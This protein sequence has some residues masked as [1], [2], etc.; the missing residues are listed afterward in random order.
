MAKEWDPVYGI[1]N[2]GAEL[3]NPKTVQQQQQAIPTDLVPAE[4]ALQQLMQ[5]PIAELKPV[6]TVLP[7]FPG[8]YA[9]N[10]KEMQQYS[11]NVAS[12]ETFKNEKPFEYAIK[13]GKLLDLQAL[14]NINPN[15]SQNPTYSS[16]I[17]QGEKLIPF[18][19]KKNIPLRNEII[20]I[21]IENK[22][23]PRAFLSQVLHETR[24]F[25]DFLNNNPGGV[26]PSAKI[27]AFIKS[28]PVEIRRQVAEKLTQVKRTREPLKGTIQQLKH[29]FYHPSAQFVM[30]KKDIEIISLEPDTIN[31]LNSTLKQAQLTN[32]PESWAI[33]ESKLKV[34][35]ELNPEKSV[36]IK[37]K[38]GEL[39]DVT[40]NSYFQVTQPFMSYQQPKHGFLDMLRAQK[41]GRDTSTVMWDPTNP[42][43]IIRLLDGKEIGRYK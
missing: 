34:L 16:S 42:A 22:I 20:N 25:K 10:T 33:L 8:P 32:D 35:R 1:M 36:K 31:E 21:A 23:D 15:Y 7:Q 43:E 27:E 19:E 29:Y 18:I 12:F 17:L 3:L 41:G 6:M 30:P 4:Q 5:Q 37:N 26:K 40:K 28:Q 24:N 9:P 13:P 14:S 2:T 39:I 11:T 38:A